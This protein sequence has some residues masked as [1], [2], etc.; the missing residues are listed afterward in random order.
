MAYDLS[1]I[2][3]VIWDLDN[4]LYRYNDI[5][6]R[7]CNHAA[8]QTAI[9]LG[10]D[11]EFDKAVALATESE[12][13]H[14]SSFKFFADYG[15]K[16]EDFHIPYHKS[17]DTTIVEKNLEMKEALESLSLPM[18]IL[19][20]ASRDWAARTINHLEI[21]SIFGDGNTICFEDT[22][23]LSKAA[24]RKGFE[25]G[26]DVIGTKANETLMVEDLARNL[27]HAKDMGMTTA[28]V[29][30]GQIPEDADTL[31]DM[32]F[33]DTLELMRALGAYAR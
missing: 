22:G 2:R 1:H 28:L 15:L 20:N 24:S 30:H 3:G 18:V 29:H 27:F 11:M 9:G 19:T 26:L 5:F 4:T 8:A 17:V 16:Y 32:F 33:Q 10:L 31:V 6:I 7:A 12:R 23:N 25:M 13:Q 21:S 14:G